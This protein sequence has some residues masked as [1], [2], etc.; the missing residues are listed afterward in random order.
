MI[1]CVNCGSQLAGQQPAAEA[2]AGSTACP[3]CGQIEEQGHMFCTNCGA[4]LPL[5]QP[6]T[7]PVSSRTGRGAVF[8]PVA[9]KRRGNQS[10]LLVP[11]SLAAGVAAGVG[12]AFL[13]RNI[14][15]LE[16]ISPS[17]WPAHGLVVF[18]SPSF[19]QVVIEE[20]SG[21]AFTVGRTGKSGSLSIPDLPAGSYRLTLSAPGCL[22]AVKDIQ[23]EEN[24]A[25]ILG[26]P[27]R[28]DLASPGKRP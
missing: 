27:A 5:A 19:A 7:A 14:G 18:A 16:K 28:I 21:K 9:S 11:L 12:L 1:F 24:Q 26:Y 2:H 17:G 4:T 13:A 3:Q 23:V 15:L 22:P 25:L 6:A 20:R 8:K 10:P